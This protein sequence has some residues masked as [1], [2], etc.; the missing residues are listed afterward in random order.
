MLPYLDSVIMRDLGVDLTR[1]DVSVSAVV[2]PVF[3]TRQSIQPADFKF[4]NSDMMRQPQ[5]LEMVVV[6]SWLRKVLAYAT[7]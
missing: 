3:S 5:R 7:R 6:M 2:L 4:V 1:N